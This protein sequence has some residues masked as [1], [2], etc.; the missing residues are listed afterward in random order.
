MATIVIGGH[1]SGAGKTSLICGL[2]QAMPEHNWTAIKITQCSHQDGAK[3]CDCD[4]QGSAY[5]I[6]EEKDPVGRTDTSRYLAAGA[7]RSIWVRTVPGYLYKVMPRI[8]EEI[9]QS[10][11]V[12]IESNSLMEFLR[13]D[14]YAMVVSREVEDFKP[15]ALRHLN[16][17]DA[18]LVTG[19]SNLS[20]L[21][22]PDAITRYAGPR[23]SFDAARQ[24]SPGFFAF[25][26]R[27]LDAK[28][29]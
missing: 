15:S 1:A 2:I 22:W 14:V 6:S 4:L 17:T 10:G 29:S 11:N 16:L 19:V 7:L 23:F 8:E 26:R 21:H 28:R 18:I 24:A 12:V 27:H 5:A 20:E 3:L 25:V 9:A 13:P